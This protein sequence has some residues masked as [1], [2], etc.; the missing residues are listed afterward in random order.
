MEQQQ[1]EILGHCKVK[2]IAAGLQ[3]LFSR[4][5]YIIEF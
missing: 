5:E 2:H 4:P 1:C 3:I